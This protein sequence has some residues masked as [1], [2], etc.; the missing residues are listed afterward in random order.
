MHSIIQYGLVRRAT[1]DIEI[2]GV[3]IA[4]GDWITC[5]L[6]SGNRDEAVYKCPHALDPAQPQVPHL[7]FGYGVHQCVG[8]S[9]ARV[10]LRV[11][12]RLL[13]AMFPDLRLVRPVEEL[14]YRED[15]FVYGLYELPVR[16]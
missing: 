5:L 11:V 4:E 3:H 2:G 16:W 13:F 6:A 9:L 10:E 12:L 15:M 14:R 1:A 8:M 7:T